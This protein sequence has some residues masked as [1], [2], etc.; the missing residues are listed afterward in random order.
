MVTLDGIHTIE[1]AC[2]SGGVLIVGGGLAGQ[3]CA[4]TLRARGF[5]GEVRIVT[6]EGRRP[7][8]RP[9]LSKAVLAGER[10]TDVA[11]L[12]TGRLVCRKGSGHRRRRP[13]CCPRPRDQDR[14]AYLRRDSRLRRGGCG[15][16]Q[17]AAQAPRHRDVHQHSPPAHGHRCSSASP[18]PRPRYQPDRR[19]SRL[20]RSR[21]GGDRAKARLSG[22]GPRGRP[23]SARARTHA[24]VGGLAGGAS[25]LR[26]SRR[27][28][29]RPRLAVWRGA[30]RR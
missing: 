27:P 18:G 16:R 3:R 28:F 20:H 1:V 25:S 30:W 23:D 14:N 7:Y 22:H 21:G 26:R 9:P 4:E 15:N 8:D 2:V 6:E 12:P 11:G 17:S 10:S 29:L 5:D 19:R 24:G 13:R